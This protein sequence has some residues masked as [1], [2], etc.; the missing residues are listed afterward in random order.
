MGPHGQGER[1][2]LASPAHAGCFIPALSRECLEFSHTWSFGFPCGAGGKEPA[3]Q[4][5]RGRFDPWVG[6]T[7]WRRKMT[8][9]PAFLPEKFRGQEKPSGL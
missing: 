1:R 8:A 6:K 7:S 2:G 4:G 3:R 9:H 5:R